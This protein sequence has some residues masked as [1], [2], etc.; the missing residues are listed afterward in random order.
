MKVVRSSKKTYSKPTYNSP[1]LL[2]CVNTKGLKVTGT[3]ECAMDILD[4][5]LMG[6]EGPLSN[7]EYI[8]GS[9][10]SNFPI[11]KAL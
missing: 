9:K 2:T 8:L 3:S 11:L 10:V 1:G 4:S 7:T 6:E 5:T